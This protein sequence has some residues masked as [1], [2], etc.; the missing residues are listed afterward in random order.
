MGNESLTKFIVVTV[1]TA[2]VYIVGIFFAD[3]FTPEIPV[4]IDFK[5]FFIPFTLLALLPVRLMALAIGIG[6]ALGETLY[7]LTLEGLG[8]GDPISIIGFIVGFYIAGLIF[9]N[10]QP[11]YV[12]LVIGAIV[13]S[14]IQWSVEGLGLL[15][16][17]DETFGIYLRGIIGNTITHGIIMG[18]IPLVILVPLLHGRIER[19]LGFAPKPT[20][21]ETSS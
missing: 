15:I 3:G 1:I 6:S 19:S 4:D 21:K 13:G 18:A 11:A 8:P 2:A 7:D 5:S 17:A 12:R 9:G 14:A 20:P 10:E 16:I